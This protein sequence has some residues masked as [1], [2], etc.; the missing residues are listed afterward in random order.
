MV[1]NAGGSAFLANTTVK[2]CFYGSFIRFRLALNKAAYD[3][4]LSLRPRFLQ[5]ALSVRKA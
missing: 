5:S 4:T 2:I 1:I 3:A